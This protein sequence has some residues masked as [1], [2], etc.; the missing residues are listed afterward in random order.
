MVASALAALALLVAFMW[1]SWASS[2]AI[3]SVNQRRESEPRI[4]RLLGYEAV[5]E[6]LA[7]AVEDA[8]DQLSGV[9]FVGEDVNQ[10]GARLQQTLRNYA[11]NSGLTVVGSRLE[12]SEPN[13]TDLADFVRLAVELR[14][15]GPP[16]AL[17]AFLLDI[18]THRP[19]LSAHSLE[20]Q[21]PAA[22]RRPGDED[23]VDAGRLIIQLKVVALRV[24]S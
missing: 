15:E 9:A 4:A 19:Q 20:I 18:S 16:I 1:G 8:E 10:A 3:E 11:E 23:Q 21:K 13:Q 24:S 5:A 6:E 14:L 17:D 7:R 2:L 22:R 12:M